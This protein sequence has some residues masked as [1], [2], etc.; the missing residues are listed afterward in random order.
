METNTRSDLRNVAIIAHVDHGKTTLLD[1]MFRQCGLFR[2]GQEVQ[3]RI[4]DR[5]DLERERGITIAAKNCSIRYR[6]VKMN[7]VDT[8]GHADFGGEV[9][10][11]LSMVDGALLLV[12]A[13]EGPLPQTRFVLQKAL[14]SH[15]AMLVI[16]NKVDRKDARPEE[17]LDEIYDLFI[18][19]R[20][21]EDQL[22]FPVF[23][24]VGREG[25][26]STDF[27]NPGKDLKPILDAVID[28]L[29]APA[30]PAEDSFRMMVSDLDYSDFMGRLAVGKVV[31]GSSR[32]RDEML[33]LGAD[34]QAR[35]LKVTSLQLYEGLALSEAREVRVGDIV[36]ISGIEDV[37]IGDTICKADPEG[38]TPAPLPRLCVD[39]PTV[40]VSIGINTSPLVGKEG[41]YVQA[42]NLR[43]R[44]RKETLRDVSIFVEDDPERESL[45]VKGRGELQ[46][47]ILI[48]TMRR[49]GYELSVGRTQVILKQQNGETLEPMEHVCVDCLDQHQGLVT[50]KLLSRRGN[51]EKMEHGSSDRVLLEFIVPSRGLI[52]YRDEFL[53]DTRGQGVLHRRVVGY[54]PF[55]GEFELS[56]NGSLV[57]DRAG[58]A[59]AY[60]LFHLQP[61]GRLFVRPND[62]VYEGMIVGEHNRGNDLN[63]NPCREKKLTNLRAAGRD[64][65]IILTPVQPMT[66]EQALQFIRDDERV[67]VT[68][69]SIRIRKAELMANKRK[70]RG[71]RM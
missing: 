11:A 23:Y 19:L 70:G 44:L 60:G 51:L 56:R 71:S 22:D 16:I 54:G 1:Q 35:P 45:E 46:L 29:P 14:A 37:L 12:D 2:K 52:G 57:S 9:E 58:Q 26:A 69:K 53:T 10:R 30:I 4:L 62:V 21:E 68:P 3:E 40:S 42:R 28:R 50:D 7:I 39:E 65:N 41:R 47:A 64:E 33:C 15:L 6:G 25:I 55:R 43:D 24:A 63:V 48:E 18:D 67:E 49:E 34:G 61:R 17:V 38:R 20:A 27:R 8:P 32:L 13:A 31:A 59:V 5:L 66:L 36:V